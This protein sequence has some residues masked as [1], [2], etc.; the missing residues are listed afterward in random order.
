[1]EGSESPFRRNRT[2]TVAALSTSLFFACAG[3]PPD[4]DSTATVPDCRDHVVLRVTPDVGNADEAYVC[5]GFD[6]GAA[7]GA[8][9]RSVH[10]SIGQ[11][12]GVTLHHAILYTVPTDFPDGPTPC[13]G[14]PDGGV[15]LHVWSPGGSALELPN[16]VGLR[17]PE[18]TKRFVIET[19]VLRT[20]AGGAA[21]S[22]VDI[23]AG[24]APPHEAALVGMGAPV[25]AIRPMHEEFSSGSCSLAGDVHL[26]S[27]WPHMHLAGKE[28]VG[29]LVRGDG[30]TE[31]LVDVVPWDF[32]NQKTYPL[33]VDAAA[34]DSIRA[35][36]TWNNETASTILPGP[37]TTDEM[38]NIAFIGWPAAA[39]ACH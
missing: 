14:M 28:I 8:Y 2:R 16:D 18:A 4:G 15:E 31:K 29:E 9:V 27:I 36:C 12:G 11:G 23:C 10:W 38:C 26:W 39:A 24:G 25:P 37:R 34:G 13:G 32:T 22:E 21:T 30:G 35:S 5:Y 1:M 17:L 19:H 3:A 7:A 6:A 33:S 20:G